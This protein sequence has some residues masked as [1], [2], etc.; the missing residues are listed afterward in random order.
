MPSPKRTPHQGLSP[1]AG[2]RRSNKGR[3]RKAISFRQL[4]LA[5]LPSRRIVPF[6]ASLARR[7]REVVVIA[8]WHK[9]PRDGETHPART[10]LLF[11][12]SNCSHLLQ[13]NETTQHTQKATEQWREIR[14]K[15]KKAMC[16]EQI[17]A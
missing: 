5:V 1:R 10:L 11:S 17:M 7:L 9:G 12:T 3:N 15:E 13:P 8:K 14:K 4:L 2:R 16:N 6:E